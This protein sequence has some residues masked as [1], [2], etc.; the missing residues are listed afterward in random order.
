[1]AEAGD[2]QTIRRHVTYRGRV[3]GVGFRYTAVHLARGRDVVGW[4]R[5]CADGTVELEVQGPSG[6]VQQLLA[7][8]RAHFGDQITDEAAAERP[9][10]S[11]E[12][13]FEIRY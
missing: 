3:Q 8:I 2:A 7:S 6:D 10:S 5:N 4:V 9:V 13:G 1:M 11:G 12:G